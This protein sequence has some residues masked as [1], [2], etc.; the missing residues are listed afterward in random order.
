MRIS[1]VAPTKPITPE[2]SR[3]NGLKQRVKQAQAAV[4]A[5]RQRQQAAKAQKQIA[6]LVRPAS[7]KPISG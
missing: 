3:V 5:E 6:K 4:A 7:P 1:E 2:Q